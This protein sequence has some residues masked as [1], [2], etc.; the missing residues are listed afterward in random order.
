MIVSGG[1]GHRLEAL[2]PDRPRAPRTGVAP[3]TGTYWT[4]SCLSVLGREAVASSP[5]T[6]AAPA[7][8]E[9]DRSPPPPRASPP[10]TRSAPACIHRR[11]PPRSVGKGPNGN[12]DLNP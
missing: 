12:H 6:S 5:S 1:A 7:Q 10:R 11:R 4:D 2:I 9:G 8:P 3:E